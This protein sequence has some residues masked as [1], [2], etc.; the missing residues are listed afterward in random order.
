MKSSPKNPLDEGLSF[1]QKRNSFLKLAVIILGIVAA[2]ICR[3]YVLSFVV[4]ANMLLFL[5]SLSIVKAFLYTTMK[6]SFFWIFYLLVSQLMYVSFDI[7]VKFIVRF[8]LMLQLSCFLLKSFSRDRLLYE[9][10]FLFKYRA[11]NWMLNFFS[12]FY[13]IFNSIVQSYKSSGVDMWSVKQKFSV[14]YLEKLM[15]IIRGIFDNS[16][17]IKSSLPLNPKTDFKC[18][19]HG[20]FSLLDPY[21]WGV[22]LFYCGA[23]FISQ[24]RVFTVG[25][26]WGV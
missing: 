14:A 3:I 13:H 23:I 8:L 12:Y 11:F 25:F 6:L 5:P 10:S 24:T 19:E 4:L 26:K 9:L 2:F 15:E 21:L 20:K 16:E 18:E 22:I 7:Q 17:S 1:F